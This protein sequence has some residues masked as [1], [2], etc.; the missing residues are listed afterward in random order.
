MARTPTPKPKQQDWLPYFLARFPQFRAFFEGGQPEVD[1]RNIFGDDL[2]NL[3]RD[4]AANPNKYD[5]TTEEGLTAFDTLVMST[6]YYQNV[7]AKKKAFDSSTVGDQKAAIEKAR[8]EIAAAYGDYYLTTNELESLATDVARS[9]LDGMARQYYVAQKVGT[10]KRGRD[11]L[12]FTSEAADIQKIARQ[13][14]YN[15]SDLNDQIISA[16]TG[17]VYNPTGSILTADAIREKA[18]RIAKAAYYHLGEQLDSG[19][20][21]DEIFEPYRQTAAR[22]LEMSPEQISLNDPLYSAAL[23]PVENRQMSLSEWSRMIR[24]DSRYGYQYTTAANQAA[25]NIGL[26]IARAFGSYK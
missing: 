26:A 6:G 14:N 23:N 11:D 22:T 18:K 17:T 4:L 20:T 19:L 1:A 7:D 2:F 10:R 8:I 24:T 5:F 13:Y 25:T 16:V 9:G 3:I 12:L 15:P 21:L